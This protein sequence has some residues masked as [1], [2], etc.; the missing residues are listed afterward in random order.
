M[1][2]YFYAGPHRQ[3]LT[4][5]YQSGFTADCPVKAGDFRFGGARWPPQRRSS[6]GR[7]RTTRR[8]P[9]PAGGH[10]GGCDWLRELARTAVLPRISTGCRGVT[11]RIHRW[12]HALLGQS[13]N[14]YPWP[15]S[16]HTVT[17]CC[18]WGAAWYLVL[19][20][21]LASMRQVPGLLKVT[22]E[23]EIEHTSALDESIVTITG[24]PDAP[25]DT[26]TE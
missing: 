19:P 20:A 2:A 14:T 21:W 23:P 1:H 26:V 11:R 18:T 8:P 22:V 5:V 9:H 4:G 17:V 13:G 10:S 16:I 12:D 25:P 15:H 6:R 24:L 7:P 3:A